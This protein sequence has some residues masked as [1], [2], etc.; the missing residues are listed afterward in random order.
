MRGGST[1]LHSAV[2]ANTIQIDL[3]QY[4]ILVLVFNVEGRTREKFIV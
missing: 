2:S 3:N 4:F 1:L